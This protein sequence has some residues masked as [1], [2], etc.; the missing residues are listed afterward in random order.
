MKWAASINHPKPLEFE[1]I[2]DKNA[3]FYL[4]IIEANKCIRDYLQD[5]FEDAVD[6]ALEDFEVPKNAWK[7]IKNSRFR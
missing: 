6:M 2:E 3:G 7:P 4:L 5:T 1:I